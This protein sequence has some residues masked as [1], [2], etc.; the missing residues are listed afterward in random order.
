MQNKENKRLT[1]M[2]GGFSTVPEAAAYLGVS[3]SLIYTLMETRQL[4]Y[5]RFGRTR[6]IPRTGLRDY[7]ARNLVTASRPTVQ[8]GQAPET[9]N[10][11]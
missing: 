5:A 6:R 9:N 8:A 4:P 1:L 10:L 11:D 3:R 7:A 2:D